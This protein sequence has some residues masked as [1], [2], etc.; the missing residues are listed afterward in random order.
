MAGMFYSLKDVMTKMN[1]TEDEVSALV[2][3]GRLREF[4]DGPNVLFKIDEVE[5][6]MS[7]TTFM[8]AQKSAAKPQDEEVELVIEGEEEKPKS[9]ADTTAVASEGINVLG[10]TDTEISLTDDTLAA[11]RASGATAIIEGALSGTRPGA[12]E[13]SLEELEKNV[14][15][16]T[17]GSGSGLLDLS[18]QADDTSL[19]GILDE[20]YTP[21]GEEGKEA[22]QAKEGPEVE[23]AAEADQLIEQPPAD[24]A[25]A[26]PMP[27]E[28]VAAV[29][30]AP[31]LYIEPAPDAAN[32][33]LSIMLFVPLL[34]VVYAI[35]VA[36][37]G[38]KEIASSVLAFK[39]L[40]WPI[41]GGAALITAILSAMAF[42]GGGKKTPKAPKPK[43]EKKSKKGKK[44]E[45]VVEAPAAGTTAV[46]AAPAQVEAPEEV[47]A[48]EEPLGAEEDLKL[49]DLDLSDVKDI[50]D[51]DKL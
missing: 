11:T 50:S 32:K 9:D 17:F 47:A 16:D 35:V 12:G 51:E 13:P 25:A 21:E 5:S 10:E 22:K 26:E 1:K 20:I 29:A 19:G 8:A 28:E 6:L 48:V 37:A 15:L 23:L 43:K 46:A 38:Q 42:M 14:N 2:K 33:M 44:E 24:L 39:G 31:A 27:A 30:A 34:A 7:D 18:L 45:P 3:Q 4:R 40:T 49:E 36:M 41:V